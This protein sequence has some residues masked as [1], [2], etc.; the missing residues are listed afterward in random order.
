MVCRRKHYNEE[1]RQKSNTFEE[2]NFLTLKNEIKMYVHR[3]FFFNSP[4]YQTF[5]FISLDLSSTLQ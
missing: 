5:L 4:P 2:V 3:V 1:I